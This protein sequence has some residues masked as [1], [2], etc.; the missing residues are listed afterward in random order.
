MV[1][2]ETPVDARVESPAPAS[3]EPVVA[4]AG[5]SWLRRNWILLT[6]VATTVV[7][8]ILAKHFVYPA[9]SWNRDETT[10]LWQVDVL[11]AGRVFTPDAN[12][13]QFFWPWLNGIRDGGFFSQYT[14]GWPLVLWVSEGVFGS[15][16]AAIPFGA[17]LAVLG[18]YAFTKEVTRN[19]QLALVASALMV[20]SPLLVIQGGTYLPYLFSLGLGL[21]FGTAFFVGIRKH[22]E[23]WL[24][25]AGFILGWLLLTRPFDAVLWALPMFAYAAIVHWRKWRLLWHAVFFTGMGVAPFFIV[26][27]LYNYNVTGSFTQFPITAKEPLDSFGFGPR[28]LMPIGD[29]FHYTIRSAVKSTAHNLRV[30]PPFLVGGW[31][32]AVVAA[33]GVWLRRRDRT[34]LVFL[35]IAASLPLG[36]FF[37][38]GNLL[39]GRAAGLSGPIYFVPLYAPACVFIATV[40]IAAWRRRRALGVALAVV[41]AAA[42]IP[43]LV[44]KIDVNHKISAA[45]KPWQGVTDSI[46]GRALVFVENSGPYLMHLNPYS[47]NEPNLGGRLLYAVDRGPENLALI[48]KYPNRTPYMERTTDYRFDDPVGYHDAPVPHVS[49]F[50]LHVIHGR[51]VTLRVR[52]TAGP[53]QPVVTAYLQ[54]GDKVERRTLSTTAKP[55][56][57]FETDWTVSPSGT[58]ESASGAAVGIDQSSGTVRAGLLTAP[59]PGANASDVKYEEFAYAANHS[60]GTMN[61][62]YPSRAFATQDTTRP[63]DIREVRHAPGLD[64]QLTTNW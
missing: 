2:V 20:A 18:T 26:T 57:T 61:V 31:V 6:I 24:V 44:S 47:S 19:R 30:F 27:L 54:I 37:F 16:I 39:S 49:L 14:L 60:D 34:T 40:L 63:L 8:A 56:E 59:A 22:S 35:G 15:P 53:H 13:P 41:L 50:R 9:F 38:W 45:Q 23:L 11:R 48:D 33:V 42:T 51:T 4:D 52:A 58:P 10:Y 17:V 62:L 5:P 7:V 46:E 1:A 29:I 21:L 43:S 32:G 64:V 55:G 36:Y 25:G 28:R 12:F 3:A